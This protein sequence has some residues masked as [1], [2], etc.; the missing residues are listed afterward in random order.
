MPG[1]TTDYVVPNPG[2]PVDGPIVGGN[3][4]DILIGDPGGSQINPGQSANIAM[5]L[6]TSGSMGTS[7]PFGGSS[8]TRI[9]ALKQATIAALQDLTHTG[10]E[11]IHVDL[12]TFSTHS[13]HLGT[14]D[15]IVNGVVQQYALN[16]AIAAIN[17]LNADGG[18]NYE[19]GLGT[20][21]Q[22]I[23][24][25]QAVPI[26]QSD[27]SDHN[28]AGGTSNNDSAATLKDASGI[29]YALVSGWGST[30]SDI[31]DA[32]GST[33]SGWGVEGG[34]DANKL[35]PQEVLRFDF[36]PGTDFDGAWN[37]LHHRRI[38]WPAHCCGGIRVGQLW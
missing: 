22:W 18:T 5:V 9:A 31:R 24:G 29:A 26:T 13:T 6:D 11:N 15:L 28:L 35:D 17:T 12:T 7:I 27:T 25:S 2:G 23:G 10:A 32:N 21:A 20:A 16:Q 8:I 30:T 33:S 1:S 3:G 36:G 37:Q 19:A 4:A 14:Y 38:Q 34:A